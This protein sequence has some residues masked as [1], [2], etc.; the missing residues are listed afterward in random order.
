MDSMPLFI[1]A[2]IALILTPGPDVI[3]VVT[4][5]MAGGRRAGL[6][7][8]LGV[9]G[10]IFVHTLA[11]TVGLAALLEASILAFWTVKIAG[12]IYLVWLGLRMFRDR[13]ELTLAAGGLRAFDAKRCFLQGFLSNVLNPKVA[14][15]FV[16][17]LPQFA[18][19]TAP[20]RAAQM[21]TLGLIFASMG[22]VY[23]AA[24][25]LFAGSLGGWLQRRRGVATRI[26]SVSGGLLMLLGLRL[27][28]PQRH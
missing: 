28:I 20:H 7:S 9:T 15:F 8:S 19:P 11:A 25:G 22:V 14:L 23:L 16:S 26:R 21:L 6:I 27:L 5:G 18:D 1:I 2:S 24:L 12:G 3:Y 13:S 10:G 17:F 4:R